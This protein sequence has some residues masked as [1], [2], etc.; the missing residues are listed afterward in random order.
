MKIEKSPSTISTF[1]A[2][3]FVPRYIRT[4]EI[5]KEGKEIFFVL[6]DVGQSNLRLCYSA[7]LATPEE[8]KLIM[9]GFQVGNLADLEGR[10]S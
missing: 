3:G 4:Y 2:Y 5:N 7:G 6:T 10:I 1:D 9:K 8:I